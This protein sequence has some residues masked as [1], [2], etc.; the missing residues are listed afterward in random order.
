MGVSYL[1]I[2][3]IELNGVDWVGLDHDRGWWKDFVNAVINHWFL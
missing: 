2:E 3:R 1:D